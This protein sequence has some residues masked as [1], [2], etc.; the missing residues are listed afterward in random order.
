MLESLMLNNCILGPE[1]QRKANEPML[2]D[3]T[4][5]ADGPTTVRT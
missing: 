5:Q 4:V 3:C 2:V 1:I